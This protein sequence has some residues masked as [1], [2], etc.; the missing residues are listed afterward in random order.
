LFLILLIL[1]ALLSP[2]VFAA[3]PARVTIHL[4]ESHAPSARLN[5]SGPFRFIEP[6]REVPSGKYLFEADG[7][8]IHF[9]SAEKNHHFSIDAA[10]FSLTSAHGVAMQYSTSKPRR[11]TGLLNVYR[12]HGALSVI[13][14]VP[15]RDYITSVVGSES[16]FSFPLESAKAQAILTQTRVCRTRPDDVVGDS[17]QQE[18]YFGMDYVNPLVE[19]AVDNVWGQILTYH[20]QPIQIFYHSTCAGGTSDAF[21]VFGAGSSNL[22]Y[23][24]CAPCHFCGQSPFWR[25]TIRK[26][27]FVDFTREFGS[28]PEVNTYDCAKRP[29]A[30]TLH[31][32]GRI[33]DQSGYQ[34]WI[35]LGQKFGWDKA[36]GTRFKIDQV[37][38]D[39]QITSTGAGHGVGMCQWGAAG[40]ASRGKNYREILD[41]YF[42][43]TKIRKL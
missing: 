15:T 29:A 21:Q 33:I 20:N 26:I 13:N 17:T 31:K 28:I 3:M 8:T 37:G 24:K 6:A 1:F 5:V 23:M 14:T 16:N 43:G 10:K 22:P 40:M 19:K 32:D 34:F 39:V 42:P 41:F 25:P 12:E 30:L 18:S 11:Y 27:S 38:S 2:P 36:P 9:R 35:R 7:R 4:F